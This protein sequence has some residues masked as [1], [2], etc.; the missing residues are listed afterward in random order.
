MAPGEDA[1]LLPKP[2]AAGKPLQALPRW[3]LRSKTPDLAVP[4][5]ADGPTPIRPTP[6]FGLKTGR[7]ESIGKGR[8]FAPRLQRAAMRND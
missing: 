3:P 2:R 8:A 1:A 4:P 7:S 5:L 6:R